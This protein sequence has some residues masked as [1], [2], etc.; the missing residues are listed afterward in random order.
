MPRPEML[1]PG[2]L[3]VALQLGLMPAPSY[4]ALS[5][6]VGI[7]TSMAHRAVQRL[8]RASL[9]ITPHRRLAVQPFMDLVRHG[10]RHVYYAEV[11]PEAL[12]VPTAHAV[13]RLADAIVSDRPYVWPSVR[14]RVRGDSITPLFSG[15]PELPDTN[16]TL[17]EA[18]ALIDAVRVG[19]VRERRLATEFLE[20]MLEGTS[21]ADVEP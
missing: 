11:G 15:A 7:S 20:G 3:P 6:A 16:P 8:E 21:A 13:G 5:A 2:D 10:L 17:Y 1:L 12:G 14:G 18:L 9:V 4:E 19:R